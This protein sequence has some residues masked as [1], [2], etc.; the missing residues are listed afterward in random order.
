MRRAKVGDR[1]VLP[2]E[3]IIP[4]SEEV[5]DGMI[6]MFKKTKELGYY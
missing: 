4:N 5:F 1:F 2:P 6:A 3:E